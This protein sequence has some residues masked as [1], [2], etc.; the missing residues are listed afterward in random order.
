M[1]ICSNHYYG[2]CFESGTTPG[3]WQA[4]QA[5]WKRGFRE[6]WNHKYFLW[7][8]LEVR[9]FILHMGLAS[10]NPTCPSQVYFF[11]I[12][13]V[14][15]GVMA[16]AQTYPCELRRVIKN[17]SCYWSVTS[18]NKE[19]HIL[20]ISCHLSLQLRACGGLG[21]EIRRSGRWLYRECPYGRSAWIIP[22]QTKLIRRLPICWTSTWVKYHAKNITYHFFL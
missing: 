21:Q 1:A 3:T 12:C 18:W 4:F 17:E 11:F 7:L 8:W 9:A 10:E 13:K 20:P 15:R 14:I 22:I 6:V 16:A 2:F 5:F 19:W